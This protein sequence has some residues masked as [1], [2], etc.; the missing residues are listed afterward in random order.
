MSLMM[1]SRAA[2]MGM[3]LTAARQT[4]GWTGGACRRESEQS[5]GDEL[6]AHLLHLLHSFFT[7]AAVD[8]DESDESGAS[9]AKSADV[10]GASSSSGKARKK[11]RKG[12]ATAARERELQQVRGFAGLRLLLSPS[13]SLSLTRS[14][15]Q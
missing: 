12:T 5:S 13:L 11:G 15:A 8:L 9:A 1:L 14:L 3:R 7:A 6:R 4:S 10:E 2:T